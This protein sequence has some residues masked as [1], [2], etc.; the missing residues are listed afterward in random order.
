MGPIQLFGM[1]L[2]SCVFSFFALANILKRTYLQQARRSSVFEISNKIVS[3]I[4]GMIA[5]YAGF[6]IVYHTRGDII[7]NTHPWTNNVM[8]LG[9]G[10]Q[11][12][13]L[14]S[15]YFVYW[16]KV[17]DDGGDVNF[18][19]LKS[20]WIFVGQRRAIVAHH[21]WFILIAFPSTLWFRHGL[22]DFL[23]GCLYILDASTPFV[24]LRAILYEIS[25]TDGLLYVL[26]GVAMLVVFFFCRVCLF[27]FMFY[28]YSQYADISVFLVP[29]KIPKKCV[30][31]CAFMF[32]LQFYW[33][34]LMVKGAKKSH[35]EE[36]RLIFFSLTVRSSNC[37]R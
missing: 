5:A 25:A 9:I 27:P 29:F 31:S 20:I 19:Y 21:L 11:L 13:D 7:H 8:Y 12:Y 24:C 37:M 33:F 1:S 17:E 10:Y 14:G 32:A 23:V 28:S 16:S 2:F 3:A 30:C 15:M 36:N 34:L 18:G 22:G 6:V 4:H 35:R 26:N